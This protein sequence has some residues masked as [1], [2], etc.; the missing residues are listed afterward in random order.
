MCSDTTCIFKSYFVLWVVKLCHHVCTLCEVLLSLYFFHAL[1]NCLVMC[2][3]QLMKWNSCCTTCT[4]TSTRCRRRAT[5]NAQRSNSN[6]QRKN[7]YLLS[8]MW[9]DSESF[10]H[11]LWKPKS[12]LWWHTLTDNEMSRSELCL[13]PSISSELEGRGWVTGL[14]DLY[15]KETTC[16]I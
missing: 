6:A 16:A 12:V 9:T 14:L 11:F 10:W 8:P 3:H 13:P 7:F 1:C 2:Q 15:A 4:C 5:A